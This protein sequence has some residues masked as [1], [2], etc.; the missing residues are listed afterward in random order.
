MLALEPTASDDA[1]FLDFAE[2]LIAGAALASGFDHL[3]V[4]HIDHWFGPRWLGFCGKLLG[5]AGVRTRIRKGAST[6][7]PFHPNRIQS[8]RR[9]ELNESG[10][11]AY[12]HDV[13]WLHGHR[14]SQ[15]N[16]DRTLRYGLLY[17][18]YSGDTVASDKGVVMVYLIHRKWRKAWYV[19]FD[20]LPHWHISQTLAIAPQRVH[21]LLEMSSTG[22]SVGC[23]IPHTT[24]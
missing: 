4:G 20:K 23:W 24:S 9:Y 10:K 14:S 2:R 11:F 15:E 18:W 16:L 7:P 13:R 1:A 21:E 17:A 6:P 22:G 8:V 12:C 5:S 3:I 19:G